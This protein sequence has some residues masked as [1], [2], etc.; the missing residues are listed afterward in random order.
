MPEREYAL[1]TCTIHADVEV[2]FVD[3]DLAQAL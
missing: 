2:D 1:E 3:T